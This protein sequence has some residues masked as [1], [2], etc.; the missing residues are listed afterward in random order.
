MM[1]M[2]QGLPNSANLQTEISQQLELADKIN[3][4]LQQFRAKFNEMKEKAIA[5]FKSIQED[6][7]QK[8]YNKETK[9]IEKAEK[10]E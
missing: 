6:D 8:A 1:A 3:E 4:N 2:D 9:E 10:K 5:E 7:Y